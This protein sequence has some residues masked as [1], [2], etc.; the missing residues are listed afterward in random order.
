MRRAIGAPPLPLAIHMPA[1]PERR[2]SAALIMVSP[3][4]TMA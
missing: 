4:K 1:A 2:V 3:K